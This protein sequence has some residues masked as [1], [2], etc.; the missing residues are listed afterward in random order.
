M[1]MVAY[2]VMV[3]IDTVYPTQTIF[4]LTFLSS[5]YLFLECCRAVGKLWLLA[6][7][8][9]FLILGCLQLY[10]AFDASLTAPPGISSDSIKLTYIIGGCIVFVC[11]IGIAG[12]FKMNKKILGVFTVLMIVLAFG[13]LIV[14]V[15]LTSWMN[16]IESIVTSESYL[17]T[18]TSQLWLNNFLNCTYVSCCNLCDYSS[19]D[20]L[21]QEYCRPYD[22]PCSKSTSDLSPSFCN[23]IQQTDVYHSCVSAPSYRGHLLVFMKRNNLNLVILLLGSLGFIFISVGLSCY[24]T[25]A[26]K[27]KPV[28]DYVPEHHHARQSQLVHDDGS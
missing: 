21:G 22:V 18:E 5:S 13:M 7:C 27:I 9:V 28:D 20:K 17:A 26:K 1:E 12:V 24:F 16:T 23:S 10:F 14:S 6:V 8:V 2:R 25:L 3:S 11:I 19:S 15:M 4:V